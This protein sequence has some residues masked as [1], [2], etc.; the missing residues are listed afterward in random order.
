MENLTPP[1]VLAMIDRQD[2]V[3]LRTFLASKS[4]AI[5]VHRL[6]DMGQSLLQ[7]ATYR[8]WYAG[9]WLLILHGANLRYHTDDG[10]TS[11]AIACSMGHID[12]V[13][14]L[15]LEYQLSVNEVDNDNRTLLAM[16]CEHGRSDVV[17][18][19][20]DMRADTT[21]FNLT[22]SY[23]VLQV[24]C[25]YDRID[26]F[27]ILVGQVAGIERGPFRQGNSPTTLLHVAS[28]FASLHIVR[29]LLQR[30]AGVDVVNG[31]GE[32][33][34][35]VAAVEGHSDVAKLLIAYDCNIHQ[36]KQD[37]TDIGNTAMHEAVL[38]GRVEMVQLL[39]DNGADINGAGHGIMSGVTS[40]QTPLS[41]AM[42]NND[43][44]LIELLIQQGAIVPGLGVENRT[45]R[46]FILYVLRK[47]RR[48]Y[49]VERLHKHL[50]LDLARLVQQYNG[51]E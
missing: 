29:Q 27:D 5:Y 14:M 20:L 40:L 6:T 44:D 49:V 26:I 47:V 21:I 11:L 46:A 42:Y 8:G 15:I 13:K 45:M 33:A 22:N 34:L 41:M 37:G 9:V 23:T 31:Y 7:Y 51:D 4:A 2:I 10:M 32:T 36:R 39:L 19:L 18:F 30:G 35:H 1:D 24:A 12:I 50:N 17:R 48:S 25:Q 38:H 3:T 16:A 43:F 28:L